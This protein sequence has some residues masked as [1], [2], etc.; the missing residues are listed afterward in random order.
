MEQKAW[1][2]IQRFPVFGHYPT[3]LFYRFTALYR[4]SSVVATAV[5][6]GHPHDG[7]R[8]LC[9]VFLFFPIPRTSE[10]GQK[11]SAGKSTYKIDG[12]APRYVWF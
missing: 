11:V 9:F 12:W 2:I 8:A 10:K 3:K 1:A 7:A 5:T 4:G 6:R